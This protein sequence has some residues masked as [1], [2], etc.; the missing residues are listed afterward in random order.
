M[1]NVMQCQMSWNVKC[2]EMLMLMLDIW[3]QA[4]TPGLTHFGAY[5]RHLDGNF[6]HDPSWY[7]LYSILQYSAKVQQ[8]L[9]IPRRQQE[10]FPITQWGPKEWYRCLLT[11]SWTDWEGLLYQFKD[12]IQD[13]EGD[14][15]VKLSNLNSFFSSLKHLKCLIEE[16]KIWG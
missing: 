11:F 6:S 1:S 5:H 8:E 14:K 15:K 16:Q 10:W 12:D 7:L 9:H 2:H 13:I 3:P 4:E